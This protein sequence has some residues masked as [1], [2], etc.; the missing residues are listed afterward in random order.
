MRALDRKL[1]RDLARMKAQAAAIALVLASGVA[2]FVGA[3]GT[4][5]SLR[6]SEHHYY[7]SQRFAQVWSS[8]SRAPHS[9]ARTL[10]AIPGVNALD[11]RIVQQVVLDVPRLEAPA[12]GLL[13]S[14]PSR[15]EHPVNDL[16]LRRGRHVEP[17]QGDEV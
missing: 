9:V 16:Y 1:L 5:R 7:S 17:G 14:I 4:Y 10:A 2:L 12:S 15:P 8:L 3:A 6:I 11:A 13:I